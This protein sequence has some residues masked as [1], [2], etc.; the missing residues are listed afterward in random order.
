MRPRRDGG[1][2]VAVERG[3]RLID[4]EGVAGPVTEA[5]TDASVR[6]NEGACDPDGR[7]YCGSMAFS[8]RPERGAMYRFDPDGTVTEMFDKVTISNGL[9]WNA[10]G[11]TV[12]YI[13]SPTQRVDQFDYADGQWQNRRPAFEI[14]RE[15]GLPDGMAIDAEGG[16]WIAMWGGSTVRRYTTEGTVDTVI[17]LPVTQVTACAFGGHDLSTM[18]ITTSQQQTDGDQLTAGAIYAVDPGVKGVSLNQFAG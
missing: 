13:D 6:M 9:V 18:Y 14:P 4:T 10:V 2:V 17:N 3:F 7:F 11:D 8:A 1:L 16:L 15:H 5:F 12:Y